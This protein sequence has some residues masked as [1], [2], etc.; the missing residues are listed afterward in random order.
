MF[1]LR[2]FKIKMHTRRVLIFKRSLPVFA[3]LLAS[4]MLVW[5]VLFAEQK[6]Q[7]SLPVKDSTGKSGARIDMEKV[8][9]IS[10]DKKKQPLTV[11]APRIVETDSKKQLVTLYKPVA[12]YQM[13]KALITA[14]S[15]YGLA[16]Q[17]NETLFF[18]DETVATTDTGYRVVSSKITCDNKA[19]IISGPD[20]ITVT[21][22]SGELKAVGFKL[23]NKGDNIDFHGH[24]D[25]TV[26]SSDGP[27]HITSENGL[28]INQPAQTITALQAVKTVQND[29]TITAD[30]MILTYWTKE[31]NPNSRIKEII[32]TGHVTAWSPDHKV[33]G[34]H[35]VYDPKTGIITMRDHVTFYQGGSHITGD[36][37]TI[38]L[39][40][41]ESDL[42]PKKTQN[43]KPDRV[44]GRLIPTELKGNK[45]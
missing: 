11:T 41:G 19:G 31:Q 1:T 45:K 5:P 24:T 42:V 13:E 28:L 15:P 8:R 34:G 3:F 2:L 26:Q 20:P 27:V 25:T 36:K 14:Q 43:G 44:R 35:G 37:A 21:G 12:E 17:K 39:T 18:E 30:Q 32:A 10:Q 29:K 9:F 23:Y 33:T 6:E 40:T 7:F 22:P 4:L 16:D 38:N